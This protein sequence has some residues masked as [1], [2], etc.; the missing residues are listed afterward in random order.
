L[1]HMEAD[2][3]FFHYTHS[4]FVYIHMI[5]YL[6]LALNHCLSVVRDDGWIAAAA[7]CRQQSWLP[8]DSGA[9]SAI[10]T[11]VKCNT[12]TTIQLTLVFSSFI[13]RNLANHLHQYSYH[14]MQLTSLTNT[15]HSQQVRVFLERP[16]SPAADLAF[17]GTSP[18]QL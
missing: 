2:V 13:H 8:R 12:N 15:S 17:L 10:C 4:D 14:F 9:V 5:V 16:L 3:D 6:D 1:E 11:R 18:H 7:A